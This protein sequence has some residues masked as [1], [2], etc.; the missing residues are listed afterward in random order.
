VVIYDILPFQLL[1]RE[2]KVIILLLIMS[3]AK[4]TN[5]TLSLPRGRCSVPIPL[6]NRS[7]CIPTTLYSILRILPLVLIEKLPRG[8]QSF[9][10]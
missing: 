6:F 5:S 9:S 1:E 10:K 2:Q 8:Y 7:N 3:V 4:C